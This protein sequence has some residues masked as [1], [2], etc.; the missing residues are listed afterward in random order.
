MQWTLE[1][2]KI[3]N[4]VLKKFAFKKCQ[5]QCCGN[6]ILFEFVFYIPN[7]G[8]YCSHCASTKEAAFNLVYP[9]EITIQNVIERNLN[10][11]L[12]KEKNKLSLVK[13]TLKN[14]IAK[15][16]NSNTNWNPDIDKFITTVVID[17]ENALREIER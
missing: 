7:K 13:E 17:A 6:Y 5:C 1:Q 16:V 12:V 8:F 10:H 9:K 3:N 15:A 4:I 11:L 14:I 2:F